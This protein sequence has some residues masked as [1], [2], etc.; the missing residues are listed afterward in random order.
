MLVPRTQGGWQLHRRHWNEGQ[1]SNESPVA[2]TTPESGPLNGQGRLRSRRHA[3]G[4]TLAPAIQRRMHTAEFGKTTK[5]KGR[6][7]EKRGRRRKGRLHSQSRKAMHQESAAPPRSQR[8]RGLGVAY[9][10]LLGRLPKSIRSFCGRVCSTMS[11][12]IGDRVDGVAADGTTR[13]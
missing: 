12:R 7:K 5:E 8:A 2:N 1:D 4:A 11:G 9:D 6:D 13:E 10:C 3:S